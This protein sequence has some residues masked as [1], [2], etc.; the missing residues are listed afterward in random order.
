MRKQLMV[1]NFNQSVLGIEPRPIGLQPSE[2]FYLTITQLEEEISEIVYA[3]NSDDLIGVI[4]GTIDLHYFLLGKIYKLGLSPDLYEHLFEAVHRANMEKK[5]GVKEGREGFDAA[6]AIK[7]KG[8]VPPEDRI[9]SILRS[10]GVE[11]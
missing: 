7:P 2:E 6:D 9:K 8:W 4:D 11:V 1:V 3:Y 5:L 10:H